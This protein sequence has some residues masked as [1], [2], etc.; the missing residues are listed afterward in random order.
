[1]SSSRQHVARRLRTENR[2]LGLPLISATNG[3]VRL[4]RLNGVTLMKAA[5]PEPEIVTKKGKPVS[6]ILPI[7]QYRAF[8]AQSAKLYGGRCRDFERT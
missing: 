2:R 4:V 7:K 3:R 1:M 6:V 8:S 5:L